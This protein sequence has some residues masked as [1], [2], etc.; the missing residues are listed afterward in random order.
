[1]PFGSQDTLT[2][3]ALPDKGARGEK[4]T[5]T[6][7]GKAKAVPVT[8]VVDRAPDADGEE[9]LGEDSQED[10]AEEVKPP[11]LKRAKG[12]KS[13]TDKAIVAKLARVRTP[14][15]IVSCVHPVSQLM[16]RS[17]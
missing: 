4:R 11:A 17:T 14:Q 6:G 8:A 2:K 16:S 3:V 15:T 10:A 1:M 9:L 5:A 13:G 12:A 7:K